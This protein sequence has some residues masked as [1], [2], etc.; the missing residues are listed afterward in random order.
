MF[1]FGNSGMNYIDA[2]AL[3]EQLDGAL[4]I[5]GSGEL[6]RS[7]HAAGLIDRYVLQIYPIVLG[8]GTRLFADG[9]R[10]DLTLERSLTTTTGVII[11]QY[12]VAR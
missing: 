6:V 9:T 5:M 10:V 4:T 3:R 1:G 11:A 7:L 8:S 2:P 12:A